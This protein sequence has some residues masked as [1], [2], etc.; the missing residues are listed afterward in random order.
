MIAR[1]ATL[2]AATRA[3]DEELRPIA[4]I[5]PRNA[6]VADGLESLVHDF[7]FDRITALCEP[8]P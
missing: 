6:K 3:D 7:R 8:P 1:A 2:A 4:E 5:A